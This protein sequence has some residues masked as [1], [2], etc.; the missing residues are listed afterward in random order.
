[1]ALTT[2]T[3]EEAADLSNNMLVQGVIE[4]IISVDEFFNNLPLA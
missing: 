3:L 2:L 1:M 4:D